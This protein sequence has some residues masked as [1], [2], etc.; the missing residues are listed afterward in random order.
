MQSQ[1]GTV[2]PKEAGHL[3]VISLYVHLD[4]GQPSQTGGIIVFHGLPSVPWYSLEAFCPK[5]RALGRIG[6]NADTDLYFLGF[7]KAQSELHGF[8]RSGQNRH[9][10]GC[11]GKDRHLGAGEAPPL[12]ECIL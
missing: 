6:G 12:R 2:H 7:F 10:V 3:S 5:D 8:P 11:T 1:V 9:P 4:P